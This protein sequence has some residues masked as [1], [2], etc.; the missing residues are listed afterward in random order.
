MIK[1]IE[2]KCDTEFAFSRIMQALEHLVEVF[3]HTEDIEI[4][5]NYN[6]TS[7]SKI[8]KVNERINK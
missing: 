3:D 1:T 6:E 2:I 8:I 4:D 7:K 5:T